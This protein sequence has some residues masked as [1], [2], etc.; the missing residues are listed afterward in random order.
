MFR[1]DGTHDIGPRPRPTAGLFGLAEA[2]LLAEVLL[3]PKPPSPIS[4]CVEKG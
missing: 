2:S 1:A 4:R 3:Q